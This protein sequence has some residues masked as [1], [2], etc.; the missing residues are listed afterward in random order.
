MS[1]RIAVS[2]TNLDGVLLIKPSTMF[3]DFRGTYTE[4]YNKKLFAEAGINVDFIQDDISISSK[5]VLRG[6][7]GDAETWKLISCLHG[8]FYMVV[9]NWDKASPQFGEWES[10]ALSGM[11]R[12]QVLVPPK[13]GNGHLVLSDEAIF[14]YKQSTYYNRDSQFTIMWND[15]KINIWWPVRDPIM[16]RRDEGVDNA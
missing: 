11:N 16:S 8:N 10:F 3:E 13:F 14:H 4:L 2:K 1:G 7:H 9:V 5:H 12:T 15:P 6:I